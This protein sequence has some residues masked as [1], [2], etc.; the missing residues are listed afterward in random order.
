MLSLQ[1]ENSRF[2]GCLKTLQGLITGVLSAFSRTPFRGRA[3]RSEIGAISPSARVSG[4]DRGTENHRGGPPSR[5]C[6]SRWRRN[7]NYTDPPRTPSG[8]SP[9]SPPTSTTAPRSAS[10]PEP[11]GAILRRYG[12]QTRRAPGPGRMWRSAKP[13]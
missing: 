8:A 5:T 11:A 4:K 2:E 12:G 6:G 10:G 3:G 7:G 13:L 9:P 1:R